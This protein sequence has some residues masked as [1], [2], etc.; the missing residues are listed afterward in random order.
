MTY[1]RTYHYIH[2]HVYKMSCAEGDLLHL[3][4]PFFMEM[5]F[6]HTYTTCIIYVKTYMYVHTHV[7]ILNRYTHKHKNTY[8]TYHVSIMHVHIPNVL[9]L[10]NCCVCKHTHYRLNYTVQDIDPGCNC[11][12]KTLTCIQADECNDMAQC[13]Y[14]Q[15][16]HNTRTMMVMYCALC[17]ATY[18]TAC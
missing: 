3:G 15:C 18:L 4:L 17:L 13:L 9:K 5:W 14:L 12:Q 1:T 8:H 2:T 11:D 16:L 10:L 7:H 6:V